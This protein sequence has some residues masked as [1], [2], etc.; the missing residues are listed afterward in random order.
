MRL[1]DLEQME[2]KRII[3]YNFLENELA[4]KILNL[5]HEKHPD[6]S[7]SIM[8]NYIEDLLYL[9]I[10]LKENH[11]EQILDEILDSYNFNYAMSIHN[12]I[13]YLLGKPSELVEC[14]VDPK[15]WP[16]VNEIQK[17][18]HNYEL[19]TKIGLIKVTKARPL[20][21]KTTSAK[22]FRKQ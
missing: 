14:N 8:G 6:Y 4:G 20:F 5:F 16:G 18:G 13:Y 17:Y 7:F 22:V 12:S 19:D 1:I 9:Y 10:S 11:Q 21:N 3:K 15:A 2:H